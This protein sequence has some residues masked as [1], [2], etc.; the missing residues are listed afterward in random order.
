MPQ[1]GLRQ[2]DQSGGMSSPDIEVIQDL[3]IFAVERDGLEVRVDVYG[4]ADSVCGS[5]TYRFE[6]EATADDR[7]RLLL[8]WCN[9]GNAVTYVC[10]D[11]SASL[12]DENAVLSEA[13]EL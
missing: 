11:G 13:L 9:R 10:R 2:V 6:D 1:I 5:L 7:T 4:S 3:R 8:D 12:M